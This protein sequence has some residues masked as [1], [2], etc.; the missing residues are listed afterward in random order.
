MSY[1]IADSTKKYQSLLA[2][3]DFFILLAHTTKHSR[4]YLIAHPE[5]RISNRLLQRLHALIQR[6][7]QSEPIALI[8]N[9]KEFYGFSFRVNQHTL[10]PRPETE[11]MVEF[12]LA[13]IT[14]SNQKTC[15]IIDVGTGSGCIILSLAKT[16]E[17]YSLTQQISCFGLDISSDALKVARSNRHKLKPVLPVR[18]IQSNL[19]SKLPKWATTRSTY[20]VILANLPYL[21]ETIYASCPPDVKNYE[22]RTAL[23][24]DTDGLAHIIRLLFQVAHIH[25]ISP[26]LPIDLWLEI[27]PEQKNTLA[28]KISVLLPDASCVIHRDLAKKYRLVEIHLST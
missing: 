6:R 2:L 20:L 16:I 17:T 7:Q 12:A 4:E 28:K 5:Y 14:T 21:S 19:L 13:K 10:I 25:T 23:Q 22:P 18:F 9:K 11:L 3:K 8:L 24:S 26:K 1:S 27:S 15:T